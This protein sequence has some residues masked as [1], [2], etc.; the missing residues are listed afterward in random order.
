MKSIRATLKYF[1]EEKVDFGGKRHAAKLDLKI[2][3][4]AEKS[5]EERR[6]IFKKFVDEQVVRGGKIEREDEYSAVIQF[7]GKPNHILH[8][9][10]SLVTFGLWLIVWFFIAISS[11]NYRILY[12][13][14]SKGVVSESNSSRNSS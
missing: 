11:K 3:S 10:L 7:G 9:L 14:D 2:S 5:H 4:M 1:W 13:I 6:E 12:S 8:L